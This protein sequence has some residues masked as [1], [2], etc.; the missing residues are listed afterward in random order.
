LRGEPSPRGADPLL[1][2]SAD[3]S[4]AVYEENEP[5]VFR[6]DP[7][8]DVRS[9]PGSLNYSIKRDGFVTIRSGV[10]SRDGLPSDVE[11]LSDS[12]GFIRMSVQVVEAGAAQSVDAAAAIAPERIRPSLPV[13]DDFDEFWA[14]QK[15]RLLSGPVRADVGQHGEHPDGRISKVIIRMRGGR[16]IHG[17]LLR[18]KGRGPFPGL[19]RYHGSGVYPVP[20]DNGLDWT[21]RG[22]MVLSINPHPIPND[23]PSEFYLRLRTGSLADYAKRGRTSRQK[24]YFRGMFLRA[25]RAVDFLSQSE[26][27][28]GEHLI[29]EG[30]SQ[31][32]GQALAAAALSGKVTA[33]VT[34]C[35]THCDHTGPVVARAAGW[36]RIVRV[37]AGVPDP[38]QV[39]AA[40]YIDGVNFASSVRCPAMFSLGFLDDLCPP[41]GICAAYN[42]LRG[43]K[44]IRHEVDVGHV[45]TDACKAATYAWVAGQIG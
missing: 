17:W 39:E 32:G 36:P 43:P 2:V 19:V 15:E 20:A 16:N 1:R 7:G 37:R 28:D 4:K 8:E 41:T 25:T 11:V 29:A 42:S 34:S 33:L 31:G 44:E 45:H 9:L 12:P 35:S 26:D 3:R 23:M 13:P 21:A 10:L 14:E 18:P 40:R 22:V 27:W 5:V 6:V 24:V 30:H 38:Q